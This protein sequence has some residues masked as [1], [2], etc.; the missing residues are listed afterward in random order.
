MTSDLAS[1]ARALIRAIA[2]LYPDLRF[3]TSRGELPLQVGISGVRALRVQLPREGT[4]HLHSIQI[5]TATT[6]D[7]PAQTTRRSSS[8]TPSLANV[9]DRGLILNPEGTHRKGVQTLAEA[10]PWVQI[11]FDQPIDLDEV[12]LHN[13]AGHA[14][15]AAHGVQVMVEVGDG[16]WTQVYDGAAREEQVSASI[17][18][19]RRYAG[20][21]GDVAAEQAV[22]DAVR[23]I[24]LVR[25]ENKYLSRT[26]APLLGEQEG[27]V[28][29]VVN[30]ELLDA[31]LMEWTT[32]GVKRS[33]RYWTDGERD[34]YVGDTLEL[35]TEL[36]GLTDKVC[37]GFGGVLGLVRD[38]DL[39]SHDDDLDIIVAFEPDQAATLP[40]ALALVSDYLLPRGFRIYG[41][42]L[43][44]WFVARPNVY[45]KDVFVGLFEDATISWY[46]SARRLL[47]REDVFPPAEAMLR[48]HVLPV[49][50]NTIG[51]L[52]KVYGPQWRVPAPSFTHN[53]SPT[54]YSDIAGTAQAGGAPTQ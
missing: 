29:T 31:R 18:A 54:T 41:D 23:D 6:I 5:D 14:C 35:I 34:R 28:R 33:F 11:D 10:R 21:G 40:E 49:P 37:L 44:H 48:G 30:Q 16:E 2:T 22:C 47:R 36:Q 17:A 13:V 52:E 32:H 50:R 27:A 3:L 53:W 26:F 15:M 19:M 51:Y 1:L 39:I 7:L 8:T 25:F 24:I 45:K 38:G 43:S 20:S 42:E 9:L 4:L 12:V 46:P